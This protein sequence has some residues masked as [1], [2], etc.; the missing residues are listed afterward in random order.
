M[1]QKIHPWFI[2]YSAGKSLLDKKA[3]LRQWFELG[4]DSAWKGSVT[5]CLPLAAKNSTPYTPSIKPK[6]EEPLFSFT[7]NKVK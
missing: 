1:D 7:I 4:L 5:V 3:R 6:I 2:W